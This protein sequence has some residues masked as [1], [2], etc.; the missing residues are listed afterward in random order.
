MPENTD[1]NWYALSDKNILQSVGEFLKQTRLRQNKTQHN[2]ALASGIVRSTL[3]LMEKGKGG[4][5]LSFI[6]VMQTLG[7]L[8]LFKYFEV[9]QQISPL[10]LAKLEHSK[11]ERASHRITVADQNKKIDW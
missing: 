6:Q 1:K 3:A 7:Q 9:G 4:T 11:R 10:Q 2:V 5:L 8:H